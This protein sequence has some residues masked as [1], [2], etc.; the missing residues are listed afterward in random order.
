MLRYTNTAI[1]NLVTLK[2]APVNRSDAHGRDC[3]NKTNSNESFFCHVIISSNNID[4]FL[5]TEAWLKVTSF[6]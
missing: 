4:F 2:P 3:D 1:R 6:L 5:V